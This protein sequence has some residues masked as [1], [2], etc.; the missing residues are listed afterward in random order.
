[1]QQTPELAW[2]LA[3]LVI[4]TGLT[5]ATYFTNQATSIEQKNERLQTIFLHVK[6]EKLE[7]TGI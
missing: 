1:M 4:S 7:R 5:N 3:A 6:I 2:K